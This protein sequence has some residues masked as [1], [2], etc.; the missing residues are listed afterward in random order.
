M[1]LKIKLM[2]GT[3]RDLDVESS[4]IF[5]SVLRQ[6]VGDL[7]SITDLTRIRLIHL[8]R[9]LN[10]TETLASHSVNDGSALH[11][12]VRPANIP[13]SVP[14]TTQPPRAV[15]QRDAP[16]RFFAGMNDQGVVLGP[17]AVE[18]PDMMAGVAFDMLGEMMRS[19]AGP[20]PSRP[21]Q[22]AA[23]ASTATAGG[24]Q[25]RGAGT[26]RP[27]SR[28]EPRR[29]DPLLNTGIPQTNERNNRVATSST[30]TTPIPP[31]PAPY[32]L[33]STD[34]RFNSIVEQ[35]LG[36]TR[37]FS[38]TIQNLTSGRTYLSNI[39]RTTPVTMDETANLA[40]NLLWDL[41][42][43]MNTLQLPLAAMSSQLRDS[44]FLQDADTLGSRVNRMSELARIRGLLNNL[45]AAAARSADALN[46]LSIELDP[47]AAATASATAT[48]GAQPA[49]TPARLTGRAM[50]V[51]PP[52]TSTNRPRGSTMMAAVPLVVSQ[53]YMGGF[54]DDGPDDEYYEDYDEEE[55]DE[56]EPPPL[57]P[58]NARTVV[59]PTRG[60]QAARAHRRTNSGD[61]ELPDLISETSSDGSLPPLMTAAARTGPAP[62]TSRQPAVP[63]TGF[64]TPPTLSATA[65]AS[66]L[67]TLL[68]A[69]IPVTSEASEAT[70]ASE[71]DDEEEE[72]E[73]DDAPPDLTS[74]A[75]SE[76][77][78]DI[79]IVD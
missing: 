47:N 35:A 24:A 20:G 51:A 34:R 16:D 21:S 74:E 29:A 53:G 41:M 4:S 28:A 10:D 68:Q 27:P 76:E 23:A 66:Q 50:R 32:R 73:D 67:L 12:V 43:C 45:S 17:F 36:S 60:P 57:E 78:E 48:A 49:R 19:Q 39:D 30:S 75:S 61:S 54:G 15:S 9:V 8:G 72:E 2:D 37:N 63:I 46:C 64:F 40:S 11:C 44:S 52:S 25:A 31:T 3:D 62:A 14:S 65:A 59:P 13:A 6:S 70:A 1:R 18:G 22:A 33:V 38:A 79:L 71:P 26:R 42:V 7:L 58:A 56:D 69:P 55:Y 77:A 5:T